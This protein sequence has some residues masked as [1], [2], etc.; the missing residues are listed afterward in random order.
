MQLEA[1][2]LSRARE[3]GHLFPTAIFCKRFNLSSGILENWALISLGQVLPHR[4]MFNETAPVDHEGRGATISTLS[5]RMPLSLEYLMGYLLCD[6]YV[7]AFHLQSSWMW[8][9]LSIFGEIVFT[10]G[11]SGIELFRFNV[12]QLWENYFNLK[13]FKDKSNYRFNN[14][15]QLVLKFVEWQMCTSSRWGLSSSIQNKAKDLIVLG[16]S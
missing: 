12:I 13:F 7:S 10:K 15:A 6:D 1:L 9:L 5:W 3:G 11:Q 8:L 16:R 2:L 4:K 14:F